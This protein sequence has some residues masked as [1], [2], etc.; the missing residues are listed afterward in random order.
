MSHRLI[1]LSLL[2]LALLLP[3]QL[4]AQ[5]NT[6]SATFTISSAQMSVELYRSFPAVRQY[7]LPDIGLV[8][9]GSLQPDGSLLLNGTK[10][11][12]EVTVNT[13]ADRAIY[14]LSLEELKIRLFL[15]VEV[16][17]RSLVFTW[18]QPL[19]EGAV[20]VHSIAL[21]DSPLLSCASTDAAQFADA[22]MYTK[23]EGTGDTYITLDGS[24]TPDTERQGYMY[25]MLSNGGL[26]G[27]IWTNAVYDKPAGPTAR[28]NGRIWKQSIAEDAGMR[29]GIWSGDWLL[30]AEGATEPEPNPQLIVVIT[31]DANADGVVD[32]QDGAIAYRSVMRTP[33]GSERIPE[34]VVQRIVHNFGSQATNPFL[35]TLD[36]TKR[37]FIATGGLGQKVLLKGYQSEGHDSAH[38]D[39]GGNY[40]TRA[41]GLEDLNLLVDTG[42]QFNADFGVHINAQEAYP[43]AHAFNEE[44]IG[45]TNGWSWLDQAVVIDKRHDALSGNRYR[46][47]MQL[48]EEVP[49]LEFIYLDVWYQDGWESREVAREIN[50][51]GWTLATEFPTAL[52][53]DATWNHWAVDVNYGSSDLKGFHSDIARFIGN[54]LK[55]CWVAGHP[56]LGGTELMGYE[57]WQGRRDFDKFLDTTFRVNLPTKWLQH[58]RILNW[59]EDEI[60]FTGNVVA[61]LVDGKRVITQDGRVVLDG[62]SYLLPWPPDVSDGSIPERYYYYSNSADTTY[63]DYLQYLRKDKRFEIRQDQEFLL[64]FQTLTESGLQDT[65]EIDLVEGKEAVSHQGIGVVTN[66]YRIGDW[67]GFPVYGQNSPIRDPGFNEGNIDS[68]S[69]RIEDGVLG[70]QQAVIEHGNVDVIPNDYGDYELHVRP[71]AEFAMS[72]GLM[73]RETGSYCISMAV[74][75]RG[76]TP[77]RVR[78]HVK[79]TSVPPGYP[80]TAWLDS[81]SAINYVAADPKHDMAMQR[82]QL[83]VDFDTLN[84]LPQRVIEVAEG[85]AE[86]FIDDLQCVPAV[87][88]PLPEGAYFFEDFEH[89]VRGWYPFVKGDAGGANDMRT[90]LA[91]RHEPYTQRG[92]RDKLIDDV[93]GGQWSLKSHADNPGLLYRTI[94]QNLRFEP[95][96]LYIV[97]LDYE[98]SGDNDHEIVISD[99]SGA[100]IVIPLAQSLEARPILFRFRAAADGSSWFGIRKPAES[101]TDLVIDNV[102][103]KEDSE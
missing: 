12:A 78:I 70:T 98:S 39:Y 42:K 19:E 30:R 26:S 51:L 60:R 65:R 50:S 44:L 41:G 88:P 62:D 64:W 71:G 94:P 18:L 68:S 101:D 16:Q 85:D 75:V 9:E 69:G 66:S 29:T 20:Q 87:R 59:S 37:V 6:D 97:T 74:E 76:E 95:G 53:Y 77:R 49:G 21:A 83:I 103:V 15:T 82:M 24:E 89:T 38:P 1:K 72:K 79:R 31:P 73:I 92:W 7:T 3:A 27:S 90:H 14:R 57:G 80:D 47:L 100:E 17:G 86:V 45:D 54:H 99:S 23:V 28:E 61:K 2:L 32:W 35:K 13:E 52:E 56:L 10:V 33:L 40:N 93:I 25:A 84:P 48:H 36:E 91:E 63:W 67:S 102:L 34:Q 5:E 43:E 8:F 22:R 58:F 96:R 55:D 46:R 81:P 11:Q 4:N